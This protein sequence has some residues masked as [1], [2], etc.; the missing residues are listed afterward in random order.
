MSGMTLG[1]HVG[2]RNNFGQFIAACDKAATDTVR[3]VIERG[4]QLSRDNAP[5]G[6]KPDPR[7]IPLVDS[8]S[9]RMISS[10]SG[11]W[12]SVARHAL[13]IEFGA[14]PHEI[15]GNPDLA[16]YWE[17]VG[18]FFVPA[19]VYYNDPGRQTIVNHPGNA[20]QPFLRP[21]YHAVMGMAMQ[22]AAREYP[23]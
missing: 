9:S 15:P 23:G 3:D 5:I 6:H 2:L 1:A 8:I 14:T 18:K 16:F 22:M 11:E 20:A 17:T 12:K 21:A 10:R 4:A 13:A 7:T 19:S